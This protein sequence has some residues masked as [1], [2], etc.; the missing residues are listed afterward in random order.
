VTTPPSRDIDAQRRAE[1]FPVA[2]MFLP[3]SY[4]RDLVSIY[5]VVRTIDDIG[6]QATGDR[7]AQLHEFSAGIAALWR[8]EPPTQPVLQRLA[9]VVSDR[10]LSRGPFD[11]LVEANLRDQSVATYESLDDVLGYCALSA[12]PIGELV[13]EVFDQATPG[14]RERS[15]RVCNALQLL[16]HWQDVAEDHR[17]GRT[18]L[19]Q[20]DIRR[21][22]V[23]EQDLCSSTTSAA[24][25]RLIGY[26]TERASDLLESGASI[27]DDLHGC[28]RLAVA[29]YVAGGRAT[30]DA[31]RTADGDVMPGPPKPR[32]RDIA[33]HLVA[34]FR[35]TTGLTPGLSPA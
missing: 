35:G 29:G 7:V 6:D 32:K 27:V 23:S 9:S 11:R 34:Q 31:L 21:F 28:A 8:G 13:L 26:E 30:V 22:G 5:D 16:E 24:L 4:R 17:A 33:R 20:E 1:N 14:T 19:P 12:A 18:Y 2:L 10:S 15:D 25:R 3:P